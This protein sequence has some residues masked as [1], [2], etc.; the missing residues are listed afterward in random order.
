MSE[1]VDNLE[2]VDRYFRA[3]A[4]ASPSLYS[5]WRTWYDNLNPTGLFSFPGD[6]DL[7]EAY[8]R[9][10]ALNVAMGQP[11]LVALGYMPADKQPQIDVAKTFA[12]GGAPPT[13]KKGSR[14]A[15]VRWVQ[16]YLSITADGNFGSGTDAAVRKWQSSQGLTSDGIIGPASWAKMGVHSVS[17]IQAPPSG[18]LGLSGPGDTPPPQVSPTTGQQ[19][20]T[21]APTVTHKDAPAGFAPSPAASTSP[22][23]KTAPVAPTQ[24]G[25]FGSL[26][27]LSTPV[28]V[29][30]G[31]AVAAAVVASAQKPKG[32]K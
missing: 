24:A 2:A 19:T 28:K 16:Q 8:K 12:G 10:D 30:I 9:R 26:E 29:G 17:D 18:L 32:H 4:S 13:I 15:A 25:I 11:D 5:S 6:S 31:L 27:K 3:N 14:G 21:V 23:V 1:L 20:F 7:Q 22:V